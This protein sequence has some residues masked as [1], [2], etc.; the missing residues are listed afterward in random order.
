MVT[1]RAF[2]VGPDNGLLAPAAAALGVR[3]VRRLTREEFFHR[4]VSDT[5]HGRDV[6]AP[7]AAHL[8]A[9]TPP[10]SFGPE[11]TGLQPLDLPA[12]RIEPGAVHG[13]VVYVDRFGNLI[14]NIP[15]AALTSFHDPS[16]IR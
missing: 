14:T 3:A 12:P 5:F 15:A 1:D 11:L 4:P 6:F 2:F 10:E 13:E 9:G 16:R 8:A 7:V